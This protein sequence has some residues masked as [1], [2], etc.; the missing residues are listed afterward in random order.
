[1]IR[2]LL[3]VSLALVAAPIMAQA[4]G[5]YAQN[6]PGSACVPSHQFEESYFEYQDSRLVNTAGDAWSVFVA[7]CP[8]SEFVPGTTPQEL[9]AVIQDPIRQD[10]WCA[11]YDTRGKLLD[12]DWADFRTG[13]GVVAF[14]APTSGSPTSGL[15][16][17]TIHC[18]MRPGAAMQS[19]EIIWKRP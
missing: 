10:A 2:K 7:V 3:I 8:V 13:V 19:V 18:L 16:T 1:M 12:W 6:I 14:T 5:L 17:A 15:L 9:R 4:A 11:M